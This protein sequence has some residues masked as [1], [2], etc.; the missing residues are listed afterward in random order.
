MTSYVSFADFYDALTENVSYEERCGYILSLMEDAGHPMGLTLDLACGTGSLTLEFARRGIDVFGAD[1]SAEML[2]QAQNKAFGEGKQI[3]FLCQKMQELD[4]Y[5]SI[6]TCLCTLDSIN[7]LT[8]MRDVQ[9]TFN[10]VY[11][12][13]NPG[14]YFLFDANTIYKHQKILAD[15]TFVYDTEPVYCVW[16]NTLL[17]NNTVQIDLDFFEQRQNGTYVRSS[18]SFCERAYSREELERMLRQS[19]FKL[20]GCYGDMTRAL[21]GEKEQRIIFV[22]K[23]S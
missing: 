13:L 18:E 15:N 4:L 6:D 1:A 16:Q 7:H 20:E 10:R 5:S 8:D 22:A 12:F 17:E 19:N 9:E 11:R 21:P 23:K 3:L 2:C 14:G